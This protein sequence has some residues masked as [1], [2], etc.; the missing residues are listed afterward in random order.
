MRSSD[1][2]LPLQVS[3]S[4]PPLPVDTS[5]LTIFA[6]ICVISQSAKAIFKALRRLFLR[7]H[8]GC[9]KALLR[10]IQGSIKALSRL[11]QGSITALLRLY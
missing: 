1:L 6:I 7:L 2:L 10:M 5:T 9:N 3:T 11:Y 4:K 8:E